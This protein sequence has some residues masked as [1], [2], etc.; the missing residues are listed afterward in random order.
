MFRKL[1]LFSIFY[2]FNRGSQIYRFMFFTKYEVCLSIISSNIFSTLYPSF[3]DFNDTNISSFVT[4]SQLLQQA[5]FFPPYSPFFLFIVQIGWFLLIC[6]FTPLSQ[7]L[8]F[9]SSAFKTFA[10]WIFSVLKF[11]FVSALCIVF[12]VTFFSFPYRVCS[13]FQRIVIIALS[14]SF[15]LALMFVDCLFLCELR[16]SLYIE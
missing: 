15:I 9:S 4:A 6:K 13:Y 5:L 8:V 10:Y 7:M 12:I 2:F 16:F 14:C 11:S 1:T 3:Y